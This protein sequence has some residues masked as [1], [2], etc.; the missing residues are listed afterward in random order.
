M[1][2][3]VPTYL[4][5]Q[6]A[7]QTAF[8]VP[9]GLLALVT[10]AITAATA[11]G[12]FNTTVDCS[13]F[14]TI[15]VSNLRIY[16]DSLGYTVEFAKNSSDKSLLIDWGRFLDIPGTEV[17]VNQGTSPW[18]VGGTVAATQ[19]GPWT[20]SLTSGSIEIGTVDQGTAGSDPW[21][22][23]VTNTVPVTGTF[24]QAIQPVSGTITANAGTGTFLVDGSAHTQPVSGAVTTLQGT[25]PWVVSGTITTSPDVNIHDSAG[26]ALTSTGGS[27]NANITNF[28]ATQSVSGTVTS[29]QGTNPWTVGGTVAATQSGVWTTGRT[30]AL[31][32]GTDSVNVGNF[33]ATQP[34]SGTVTALQGTSPWVISGTVT[35]NIGTTGGLLLDTTFTS[36]INTLGQKTSINSTPVVLASDQSVIPVSQSGTWNITNISGT[37]SLPTGAATEATLS[38]LNSK[39][40]VVNTGAVTISAALPA[41]TNLIGHV[42][43][44]S[45]STTAVTGNVT[46]VQPTGTNLHAVID[47]GAVT[48]NQ[49]TPAATA[50]RWPVQITDGTDL[51][52]VSAGGAVLVDGSATTQPVSGTVAVIQS[53][54]PWVVSGTVTANAGTN[55]NTSALATSLNQ[56]SGGAKTQIVDSIGNVVSQTVNALDVNIKSEQSGTLTNGAET[57]ITG[58]AAQIVAANSS[59]KAIF[60]QNRGLGNVRV[61]VTGVLSTTGIELLPGGTLILEMPFCP[62]AALFG[63]REGVTNSTVGVAEVS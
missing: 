2:G 58:V 23:E 16:L 8:N 59:R 62:T 14:A 4:S 24:F 36:R 33:P 49:G 15:D 6:L 41:G 26:N 45:G 51:A 21:L 22:V 37:I 61:G 63:I 43:A 1:A 20:V 34:V 60:V 54:S 18:I 32:S 31:S 40:V 48:S 46:V 10:T 30:W 44:D 25:S 17:M 57:A 7:A 35:S 3:P 53:T 27:L 38:S 9:F 52:Q 19:S 5:T 56:T 50:N 42:I 39:V 11:A 47:S 12:E 13:L 55:L 29:L 28:P